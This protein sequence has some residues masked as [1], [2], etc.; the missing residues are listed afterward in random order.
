MRP[1]SILQPFH[2]WKAKTNC[3]LSASPLQASTTSTV[4]S[5]LLWT[6]RNL[7]LP[8]F[9]VTKQNA[10]LGISPFTYHNVKSNEIVL[11]INRTSQL[12]VFFSKVCL[13]HLFFLFLHS[14]VF[15]GFVMFCFDLRHG[16]TNRE[17]NLPSTF[18]LFK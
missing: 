12:L 8:R 14:F 16:G 5:S 18:S 17:N 10:I 4:E 6:F 15:G 9:K 11:F 1:A 13:V 3:F 7:Y 2:S